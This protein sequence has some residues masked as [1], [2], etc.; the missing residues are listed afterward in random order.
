MALFLEG[1]SLKRIGRAVLMQM[2]ALSFLVILLFKPEVF[3]AYTSGD[4]LLLSPLASAQTT[5]VVMVLMG[6]VCLLLFSRLG[7]KALR[8]ISFIFIILS[9][10]IGLAVL[11]IHLPAIPFLVSASLGMTCVVQT[12]C[13]ARCHDLRTSETLLSVGVCLAAA[14]VCS[15]LAFLMTEVHLFGAAVL[16]LLMAVSGFFISRQQYGQVRCPPSNSAANIGNAAF[17]VNSDEDEDGE[18]KTSLAAILRG[19]L[20]AGLPIMLESLFVA[21]TLGMTWNQ[22]EFDTLGDNSPLFLFGIPLSLGFV[23]VLFRTWRVSTNA[24]FLVYGAAFPVS[25]V[26]LLSIF[27]GAGAPPVVFVIAV[28]SEFCFLVLVWT[29]AL[30][31]DKS[32]VLSGALTVFYL[33]IFV[34]AFGI[35]MSLASVVPPTLSQKSITVLALLFLLYLLYCALRKSRSAVE[36][37]SNSPRAENA[38]LDEL[39][40]SRCLLL[41]R[42]YSL[43][44]RETELLPF[45][46]VGM[47][48]TEIGRRMFISPETVKTHRKRIYRKLDVTS[49]K[50]LYEVFLS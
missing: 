38:N 13:F 18:D 40:S 14:T 44:A 10:L 47:S 24:D 29:S 12:Y 17:A 16:A 15:H 23:F 8:A 5:I 27:G 32:P 49:H 31:L 33:L 22:A 21:V 43:S 1:L 39:M 34:V 36:G 26:I 7:N 19:S 50:E 11:F 45:F 28:L 48:G 20:V 35:F 30:L 2:G 6:L 3:T 4:P 41:A 9:V 46:V 42:E 37:V 25:L